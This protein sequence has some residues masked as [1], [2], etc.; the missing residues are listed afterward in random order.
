MVL[1]C[2]METVNSNRN[3]LFVLFLIFCVV[4]SA[5]VSPLLGFYCA[6]FV[7]LLFNINNLILRNIIS[8][9]SILSGCGI[10]ASRVI[11]FS[12][13]DDFYNTYIP[14]Y[15]SIRNGGSIFVEQYSGGQSL[16][17]RQCFYY[18]AN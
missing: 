7:L 2:Y 12:M 5:L 13:S 8:V 1:W 11:G 18:S 6:I 3:E 16:A 10:Y 9:I 14:I 4:L 17:C 15:E